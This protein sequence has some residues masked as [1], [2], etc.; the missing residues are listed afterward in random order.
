MLWVKQPFMLKLV[1]LAHC[2]YILRGNMSAVS[3]LKKVVIMD[4]FGFDITGN[5]CDSSI[6]LILRFLDGCIGYCCT[7]QLTI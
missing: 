2:S 5:F 4:L 6:D 7:A 1:I 3:L